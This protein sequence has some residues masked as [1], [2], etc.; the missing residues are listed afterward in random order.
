MK[1]SETHSYL[2]EIIFPFFSIDA[3]GYILNINEAAEKFTGYSSDK[4]IATDFA[5]LF[6][7]PLNARDM[8]QQVLTKGFVTG[9]PLSFCFANKP[10]HTDVLFNAVLYQYKDVKKVYAVCSDVSQYQTLKELEELK[11]KIIK[12]ITDYK[13][14][15][16]ESSMVATTDQKGII[17]YVNDNFSKISKYR[18]DELIGQDESI[19]NSGDHNEEFIRDLWATIATGET[20]KGEMK[21]KA[22]DGTYYWVDTIIVPF[23]N[24]QGKPYKYLSIR[25]DITERKKAEEEHL[26]FELIIN[27]S[28]DAIISKDLNGNIMSWN[29]GAE[30]IFGYTTK[31]A[32]GKHISLIIPPEYLSDELMIMEKIR[33][34]VHVEHYE[35][36][37][38]KKNERQ[39]HVS[40]M[41]SPIKN[42]DG[43]I[44]G[45]SK[46][47]RDITNRKSLESE[48]KQLNTE[49]EQMVE[50]RTKMLRES[51][52]ALENS[53]KELNHALKTEKELNELKSRFVTMASHEFRTPLSTILSST[54]LLENYN[55]SSEVEKRAKHLKY[56]RRA[57]TDMKSTLEDFLSLG[58]LEEGLIKPHM[59]VIS[60]DELST[61]IKDIIEEMEHHCKNQQRIVFQQQNAF[62]VYVDKK[63]FRNVLHN[64]LSNAI[65]YSPPGSIIQINSTIN[66]DQLLVSVEDK[67]IGIPE[68]D[69]EHLSDRFF[70]AKNASD[71][72]G[73]G[74]GLHIVGRYLS[75][76]NGHIE[77]NSKLNLGTT[78]SFYI[79]FKITPTN[80]NNFNH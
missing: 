79:P 44:I 59:E 4:L 62:P 39:I 21:N 80:E 54:F 8:M 41:V 25:T 75:L 12:E 61:K 45:V 16:D 47:A 40:L 10:S 17:Q 1:Q 13:Y 7:E 31:E 73:T 32:L 49:L 77:I 78:F 30:T 27:S 14:A 35:T 9:L 34:G 63:F 3:N 55:A 60:A 74:L 24:E 19:I 37:R 57:V 48:L 71:I 72:Q 20:W 29:R 18:S 5:D 66:K 67:G 53:K 33:Q 76:M 43:N 42:T 68:E 6:T 28:D 2:A 69:I 23:V 58:K 38:L 64:L 56:I 22:K 50:G 51:L 11:N 26:L 70:R 15:L 36:K 65:K 46:I 52:V